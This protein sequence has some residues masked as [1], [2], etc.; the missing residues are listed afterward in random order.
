M[1]KLIG[2]LGK[3]QGTAAAYVAIARLDHS[4]KHIFIVPGVILAY[5]LRGIH[6]TSLFGSITFGLIAA[7]LLRERTS[8]AIAEL[9]AEHERKTGT[10]AADAA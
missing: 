7:I 6:T 3:M 4:T 1:D 5:L 8:R 10:T 2:D 9:E